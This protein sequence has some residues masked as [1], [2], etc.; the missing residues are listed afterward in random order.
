MRWRIHSERQ[1][2]GSPWLSVRTLDVEQPDGDRCEYHAVRLSDV[3]AAVVIDA[4][5]RVLMLWRHR[6]L[7]DS[8][9]WELPMGI[10]EPG[11]SP[12]QAA[13]REVE[14]E[15]G[16]RPGPLAEL[17][18]A[19]PAAGIMDAAHHVFRADSATYIGE[20][21]EQNESDRIE[22]LPLADVPA[23]IERREIVSGITLVGL[24]QMLLRS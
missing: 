13:A 17:I 4:E 20:P 19:Q 12:E 8:W 15:T 6:F 21:V 5:Q 3:A 22:W 18:Y 23:L 9:A 11:E 7:T 16:W 1:V 24:Q 2:W 10:V 14:E